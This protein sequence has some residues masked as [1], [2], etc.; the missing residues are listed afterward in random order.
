LGGVAGADSQCNAL[1]QAAHLPGQ[2]RAWLS[3]STVD[4]KSRL[5]TPS[6]QVASGWVRPDHRPFAP[7]FDA[8]LSGQILNPLRIDET[9][10]DRSPPEDSV[11]VATGTTSDGTRSSGGT[12]GDW[13][14]IDPYVSG[15]GMATTFEWTNAGVYG[16]DQKAHLYCFGIDYVQPLPMVHEVG[17][18]A[19]LSQNPFLSG[20]GVTAADTLCQSEATMIGLKGTYKA[21]LSTHSASALSRFDLS[22]APWVRLDGVPWVK[23]AQD[24]AR[25]SFLTSLNVDS[26][27]GYDALLGSGA[28]TGSNN[29]ITQTLGAN[30]NDW[31]SN[32]SALNGIAG[33][34]DSSST[35]FW[36]A[37]ATF[38]IMNCD[39][40][41]ARLY[42]LQE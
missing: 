11:F 29:D 37:G 26:G 7:S 20:G 38:I 3:T 32:S 6:G 15:N 33:D 17:R 22:L 5:M 19:F 40:P 14:T 41:V 23:N 4:A 16:P 34:F 8:L 31:T 12:A 9:G 2:F 42:C 1:A 27:G 30:C 24:L 35:R 10:T 39:S 18:A 25:G 21:L 36:D 28:W 13:I